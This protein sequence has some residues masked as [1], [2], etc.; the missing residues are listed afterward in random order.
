MKDFPAF[1][2]VMGTNLIIGLVITLALCVLVGV[3]K[4]WLSL[5]LWIAVGVVFWA[6]RALLLY[7]NWKR[8]KPDEEE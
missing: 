6:I 7:R 8:N 1:W 3:Q 2:K 5:P 4:V